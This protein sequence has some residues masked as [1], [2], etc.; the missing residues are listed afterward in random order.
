[1]GVGTWAAEIVL[2]LKGQAEYSEIE[3]F[4]AIPFPDHTE[5]FTDGQK[6]RYERILKESTY[7]EIVSR[8]YSPTAYKRQSYFMVGNSQY[9]IA[10]YDQDRT[11]RSGLGQIVNYALK[12]N[13][14]I[15]FI[16]PDTADVSQ[17]VNED[18]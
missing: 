8:K 10:V 15:I 5:R 11:E 6:K 4:C 13:L 1:M 17:Y 7:Q 16:H 2:D 12:N 18:D 9:L 14:Q 3:L